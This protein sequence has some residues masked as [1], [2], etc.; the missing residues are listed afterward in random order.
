MSPTSKAVGWKRTVTENEFMSFLQ[1]RGLQNKL[2]DYFENN[3]YPFA[4][5]TLDS[6]EIK[7]R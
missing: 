6:L 1:Y 3:G 4:K 7:Q 2:M 5:L